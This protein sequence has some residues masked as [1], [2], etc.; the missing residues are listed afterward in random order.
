MIQPVPDYI[1]V[2][3]LADYQ[4]R[5]E[6]I[7]LDVRD[8]RSFQQRHLPDAVWMLPNVLAAEIDTLDNEK[9][10]IIICYHGVMAVSVMNYMREHRLQASVLK[11]GMAAVLF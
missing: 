7:L 3:N 8:Q 5:E 6:V 1:E 9:H 11:G 2:K 4:Q 10:Y